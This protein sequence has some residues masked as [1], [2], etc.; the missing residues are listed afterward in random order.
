MIEI[1]LPIFGSTKLTEEG[2]EYQYEARK[3]KYSFKETPIDL[4]VHFKEINIQN[5]SLLYTFHKRLRS[6]KL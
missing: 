6:R 1:E 5:I 2:W 4:D 3:R